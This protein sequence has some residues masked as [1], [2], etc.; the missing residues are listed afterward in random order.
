MNSPRVPP[1]LLLIACGLA[2]LCIAAPASARHGPA[3]PKTVRHYF[4]LLPQSYFEMPTARRALW[5]SGPGA[6]VDL[7]H[8]YLHFPPQDSQGAMDVTLFRY[9]GAVLVAVYLHA[10]DGV[11]DFLRYAHGHW[12]TVTAQVMPVA[13]SGDNEYALPRRG[14]TIRVTANKFNEATQERAAPTGKWVYDF[15]WR[16]G[17]FVVKR[18]R[19]AP[20]S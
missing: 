6:V 14:T 19:P 2:L 1:K 10:A 4:L 17:K 11:L 12:K 15:V 16:G 20:A 8:D 5:L 7:R 9:K 13:F 18:G 3:P